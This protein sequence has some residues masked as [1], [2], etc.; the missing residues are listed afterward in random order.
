MGFQRLCRTLQCCQCSIVPLAWWLVGV[1]VLEL[2]E[3]DFEPLNNCRLHEKVGIVQI[4][5]DELLRGLLLL[6]QVDYVDF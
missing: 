1:L 6:V 4:L 3:L 2:L 5:K